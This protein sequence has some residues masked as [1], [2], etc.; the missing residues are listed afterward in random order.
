MAD[1][2]SIDG[3]TRAAAALRHQPADRI[4]CFCEELFVDTE[5]RWLEQGLPAEQTAREDLFDYDSTKLFVDASMRFEPTL[6][7]EDEQTMT[8]ADKYGFVAV[9]N[10]LIPGIHYLEH[11]IK[12]PEDWHRHKHRLH[13]DFGELSRV[14]GITAFKPFE[15]WPRWTE[16]AAIAERKRRTGR[17]VTLEVYGPWEMIWRLRGYNEALM[18]LH[19]NRA[20]VEDMVDH[21]TG[22]IVGVVEKALR[23]GVRPD[24]LFVAEDLGSNQG[25]LFSPELIR[26]LFCPCY[27]KLG[28]FLKDRGLDFLFHSCGDVR[29]LL[30][31][32]IEVGVDALNPLQA[33]VMDVVDLKRQYGG[34][35]AFWGNINS[36]LMHDREALLAEL[37]RKVPVAMAGGGYIFCSDH[38]IPTGVDL[39]DYLFMLEEARRL[40]TYA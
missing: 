33:T 22:F 38:S 3:R 17:Y 7:E 27:Q 32:F 6:V 36:R 30:P 1:V 40:G 8:V 20:M 16:A 11:P 24:G 25:L 15:P 10:K 2:V 35:I 29:D 37:R 21:V 13:A 34:Q 12:T 23:E 18:D 14:H 19:E 28:A 26:E 31:M 39:D 5:R 4:P 9:R